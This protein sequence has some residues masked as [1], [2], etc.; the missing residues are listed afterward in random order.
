MNLREA[1]HLC[2]LRS[3]PQGHPG[4]RKVAQDIYKR[5]KEADPILGNS[6]RFVN[7]TEPG[8][9]RLSAEVRKEEKLK[10][11]DLKPVR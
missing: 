2:E 4:Y 5:I 3:S 10:L 6:M 7:F 8:L 1:F 9:E 11:R